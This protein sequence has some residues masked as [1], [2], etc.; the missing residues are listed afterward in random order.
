MQLDDFD[1]HILDLLQQDAA[2][3]AESLAGEVPLSASAIQR[4]IKRLKEDGIIRREIA[5]V[6]AE[7]LGAGV[8]FIV[9]LQ[10]EK[11]RQDLLQ[12]L[13]RWCERQVYIQ[14]AY[15]VTGEVDFVLVVTTPGMAQFEMLMQRLLE[16]NPNVRRFETNVAMSVLKQSL[17]VPIRDGYR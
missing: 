6:D 13:R 5:V 12:G 7:K 9:G 17:F 1:R 8:T 11:E 2:R 4:R 3:T 15:Y 16:D 14:Q 10:V